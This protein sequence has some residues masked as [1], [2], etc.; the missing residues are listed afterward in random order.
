MTWLIRHR[1]WVYTKV[2]VRLLAQYLWCVVPAIAR[3]PDVQWWALYGLL[4]AC[5]GALLV[6]V[7]L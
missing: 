6:L 1:H 3:D 5:V 7:I 2:W 4:W